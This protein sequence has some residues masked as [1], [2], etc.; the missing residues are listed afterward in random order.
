MKNQQPDYIYLTRIMKYYF[1]ENME[2]CC[3]LFFHVV[4]LSFISICSSAQ[5][6]QLKFNDVL[7]IDG[8]TLG[9]INGIT[10]DIHGVM[11]FSDQDYRGIIRY[12]GSKMTRFQN[13][14]KN[15]NSLGGFYPNV[16]SL[17]RQ[18]LFGSDFMEWDL[19]GMI[20]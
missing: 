5:N 4:V 17:I 12:D 16:Y 1:K 7:G 20:L 11:W 3:K 9:K 13:D 8:L 19:T 6:Q 2:K 18:E 10:R 15:T 14:P